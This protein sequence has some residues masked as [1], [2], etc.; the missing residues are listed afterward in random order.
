M[1]NLLTVTMVASATA[2]LS[3][4][5]AQDASAQVV[6]VNS[7]NF[8]SEAVRSELINYAY[9]D[10][11]DYNE[12][13]PLIETTDIDYLG[14]YDADSIEGIELLDSLQDLYLY[15]YTGEE[16]DLSESNTLS[17]LAMYLCPN[18]TSI[19]ISLNQKLEIF[20]IYEADKI[21]NVDVSDNTA[22]KS[23]SL[24]YNDNITS[25]DLSNNAALDYLQLD[26][27]DNISTVDTS[28]NTKLNSIYAWGCDNLTSFDLSNN[29]NLK[30]IT[31]H[32]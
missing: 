10:A 24:G 19:D 5:A 7:E 15:N 27:M 3:L 4:F 32:S 12:E 28:N 11:D 29:T 1:K 16:I 2:V 8:P 21:T 25:I 6:K 22:L 30:Y 18:L 17:S 23:L 26:D 14:I 9:Y 13:N 20:S 31:F